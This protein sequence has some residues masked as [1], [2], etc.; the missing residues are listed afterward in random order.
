M[1]FHR[2]VDHEEREGSF[3][4][5]TTSEACRC[6]GQSIV[7]FAIMLPLVAA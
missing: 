2:R 4:E 6:S 3:D 7:E 5:A 1:R